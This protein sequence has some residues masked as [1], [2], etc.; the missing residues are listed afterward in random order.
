MGPEKI[1]GLLAL[2]GPP[3]VFRLGLDFSV[4]FSSWMM[5]GKVALTLLL[6]GAPFFCGGYAKVLGEAH[7]ALMV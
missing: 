4:L 3:S 2:V 5:L 6:L 7:V 1:T